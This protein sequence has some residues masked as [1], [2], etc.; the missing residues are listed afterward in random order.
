MHT[1]MPVHIRRGLAALAVAC[2][3]V[4]AHSCVPM[5]ELAGMEDYGRMP[6]AFSRNQAQSLTRGK[7]ASVVALY[8]AD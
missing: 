4:G 2:V 5:P 3:S 6:V 8:F 7:N 1:G